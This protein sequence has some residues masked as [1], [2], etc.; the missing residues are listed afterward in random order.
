MAIGF[1]SVRVEISNCGRFL[2]NFTLRYRAKAAL[3]LPKPLMNGAQWRLLHC[4]MLKVQFPYISTGTGAM[5]R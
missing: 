5:L 4:Q 1:V 2:F 3:Y